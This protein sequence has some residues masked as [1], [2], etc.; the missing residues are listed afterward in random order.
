[1][2]AF[3]ESIALRT[4]GFST[5]A[6]SGLQSAT[7]L[8]MI[9]VMFI[10]GSPGGT[11]GGVKTTTVALLVIYIVSALKGNG[12]MVV[13]KRTIGQNLV[14]HAMGIFFLNLL[15]LLTGTFLLCIVENAQFIKIAFEAASALATVGSS[16]G[17]TADLTSL[18]KIVIIM[19]MYIGRIG[20]S[21][22]LIS[23][24]RHKSG[25]TASNKVSYPTGNIIVG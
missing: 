21:T 10:G 22:L 13:W 3:F 17:I 4:A 18:G 7:S 9:V 15:T 2:T 24:L 20:I 23:I 19:M 14:T 11:A 16:L 12:K 5:I 1:M 6:Y 25:N 8:L